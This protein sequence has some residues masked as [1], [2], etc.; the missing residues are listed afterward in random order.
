MLTA[1]KSFILGYTRENFGI[2]SA[3]NDK[4]VLIFDDFTTAIHLINFN[5]KVKSSAIKLLS[6]RENNDNLFF[7]FLLIKRLNFEPEAHE[8]H[9]ISKFSLFEM[10]LPKL[11]EKMR[12]SSLFSTLDSLITLHQ[13]GY[14]WRENKWKKTI[15]CYTN[16]FKIE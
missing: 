6:N 9:W 5:F 1:G 7:N 14:K 12:I 3:N 4:P 10:K 16:I 8:R 13:R 11:T 15:Y 2:K